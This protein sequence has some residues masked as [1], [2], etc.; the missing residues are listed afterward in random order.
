MTT[1]SSVSEER[2][3]QQAKQ[4]RKPGLTDMPYH[5]LDMIGDELDPK[6]LVRV[7]AL[8]ESRRGMLQVS[9]LYNVAANRA[10]A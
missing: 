4:R 9:S 10:P 3:G 8:S 7:Q 5:L 6:S 1:I 2:P